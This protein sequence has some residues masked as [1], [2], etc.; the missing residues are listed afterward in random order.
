MTNR[1][2]NRTA[3][4]TGAGQGIGEAIARRFAEEGAR[5]VIAELNPQTG[6]AVA[7]DLRAHGHEAW[8]I[9]TDVADSGSVKRMVERAAAQAGPPD[10][11]VNNAGITVFNE[12]LKLT[13]DEWRRCFAVDLDG[14]WYGCRAVLPFMVER[15]RGS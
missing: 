3:I 11:I 12:P 4:I 1:L 8:F 5:V 14:V 6:A 2:S 13:D 9:P 10:I 15:R 7:A